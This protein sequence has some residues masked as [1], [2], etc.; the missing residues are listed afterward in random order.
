M[1]RFFVTLS[2]V[3][4]LIAALWWSFISI[5]KLGY[6][7]AKD[8]QVKAALKASERIRELEEALQTKVTQVEVRYVERQKETAKDVVKSKAVISNFNDAVDSLP[9]CPNTTSTSSQNTSTSTRVDDPTSSRI[10]KECAATLAD[11]AAV[12]DELSNQVIGL[13]DYIKSVAP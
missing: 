13:Q 3:G 9:V 4:I 10:L 8:E 12:A 2:L 7:R 1:G 5:E 6:D 11:L